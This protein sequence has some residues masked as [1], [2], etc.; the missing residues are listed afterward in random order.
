MV[1]GHGIA[2]LPPW[3]KVGLRARPL[4][5]PPV[6]EG[7]SVQSVQGAPGGDSSP[8]AVYRAYID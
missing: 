7:V 5:R 1:T 8:P 3:A 6:V 2:M 4:L